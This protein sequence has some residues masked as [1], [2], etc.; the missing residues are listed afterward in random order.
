VAGRRELCTTPGIKRD[1]WSKAKAEKLSDVDVD[2]GVVS[3]M[4]TLGIG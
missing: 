2:I 1:S 3:S 4:G